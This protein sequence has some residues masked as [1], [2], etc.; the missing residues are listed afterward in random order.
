M[1]VA[2]AVGV[3]AYGAYKLGKLKQKFRIPKIKVDFE[4]DE[5]N[6]WREKEG[7]L[8]RNDTD[9]NWIDRFMYCQD[10]EMIFTPNVNPSH[11]GK[12]NSCFIWPCK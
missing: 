2:A 4:F 10:R 8:C 5:W 9:C 11:K 6:G 1:A 12:K 7:M 3:G